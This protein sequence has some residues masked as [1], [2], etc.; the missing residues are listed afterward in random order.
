MFVT[1]IYNIKSIKKFLKKYKSTLLVIIFLVITSFILLITNSK[2][3]TTLANKLADEINVEFG[4][5]IAINKATLSFNGKVDLRDFLIRD[6]K[7]DTLVFFK[8]IYLSPISLGKLVS[9]EL[10]FSSIT[11]DGLDLK[12]S[13][14]LNEDQNSLEIFLKKLN[15]KNQGSLEKLNNSGFVSNVFA[16]NSS[17]KIVNHNTKNS[18]LKIS[19]IDF[20]LIDFEFFDQDF[21]F[22]IDDLKLN[23][24][25]RIE[26]SSL[27]GKVNK[28]DSILFLE[29][30][31]FSFGK[32][33][34]NGNL[35]LDYSNIS[36]TDIYSFDFINS[37]YINLE[38]VDSK[39]SS[40]DLGK[41]LPNLKT[42]YDESWLVNT[43]IKGYLNDLFI[44]NLLLENKNNTINFNSNIKNIFHDNY[45]L[46]FD[47]INFDI[48]S[49]EIDRVFPKFFGT[50]LP[51]SL[52]TFG[53]F[54]MDG[55]V[56]FKTDYVSS[57]FN[58][59]IKQG[60]LKSDLKIFNFSNIDN[61]S[62][63]GTISGFDLDLSSFVNM[64]NI[65]KSSFK[66]EIKGKGFTKEFLN[67]SVNGKIYDLDFNNYKLLNTD[68]TG[69]IK[70]QIFDGSMLVNDDNLSLKF[71]GLIDFSEVLVDFDF[72]LNL[73]NADLNKLNFGIDSQISGLAN[74]KLRGSEIE[75]IIGDLTLSNVIFKSQGQS[76]EF[77]NFNAQ[78]RYNEDVRIVNIRSVDA[79]SG[80][81]IGEYDFFNLKNTF[82]NSFGSDYKNYVSDSGT[83]FQNISFNINFKPKFLSLFNQSIEI[84]E[85]T[86]LSGSFNSNGDYEL[87]LKSNSLKYDGLSIEEVDVK[88][89]SDNGRFEI[90]NIKSIFLEGKELVMESSFLNDT[91]FVKSNYT[92]F[93]NNI[94]KLSF[95]HTINSENNSVF[96]F[97][98][99][100]LILNNMEW[101]LNKVSNNPSLTINRNS[102]E[103]NIKNISFL[104]K[105]QSIDLNISNFKKQSKYDVSFKDVELNSFTNKNSSILFDGKINGNLFLS[106]IDQKFNGESNL[107]I[108]GL[109]SNNEL[110]GDAS[111]NF[112][113]SEN[114]KKINIDFFVINDFEKKLNLFGDF[115]IEENYYPLNLT[116][117]SNNFKISPFSNLIKNSI[118]NFEGEFNSEIKIT[119][120]STNPVFYGNIVTS[121]VAFKVPY[122]NVRYE[123]E[124]KSTFFLNDQ[125][126]YIDDFKLTNRLTNTF[127]NISGKIS[128]NLFK[129]WFLE[130]DINSENLMILNTTLNNNSLY[131]GK[132]MF[133]GNAII[134]GPEKNL[135]I[136]LKGST[137]KNT[138]LVIPIKGSNNVGDFKF[139]NYITPNSE[140]S[141]SKK[142]NKSLL[143]DL[144]IDFNSNANL[145]VILDSESQSRINGF[146]NGRLNFKINTLGNF[147][148]YGNF[149][150]EKG[151]YFYKSLGIVNREFN[152]LKGS[153][154]VWNGD[155]YL[156]DLNINA[157][158]EVPGGANPAILIQNTSFNRKIPTNVNVVL[159]GNFNEMETPDFE[160]EFPNTSGPIKS[161]LDYYLVDKEKKQ[162]QALS[163]LYQ[164]T[165]IDEVS[166]STVSSQAITNNLFQSASGLIDNIFAN[167]DDKMNIGVNYLKGDKNAS[168]S[169]LNRDRLGLTLK[170]EISDKI[171]INGKIGVPVGG[172]EENVVIGDV[173]IEFLL[174]DEGNLKARFFNK[175]NEYQYFGNDIGYTQGMGISYEIDF[176]NIKNLFRKNKDSKS[177]KKSN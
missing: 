20:S 59:I 44:E 91:L 5:E 131:Y 68:I 65:K 133:N 35:K 118:S 165:F 122:L 168:S 166:L 33:N 107:V 29:N 45:S 43:N 48:N 100:D 77:D 58:L 21:N 74:V 130:L 97:T 42:N 78:L 129:N 138:S 76:T 89:D 157:K 177:R 14:Y 53:R 153:R 139:L 90:K 37:T 61:A 66:F 159:A 30:S 64:R 112:K 69:N 110:I 101:S 172:I 152:I 52:K 55:Y 27:K 41:M 80:I 18:R 171:L 17:I 93:S 7:N 162:K 26:L 154:I 22:I 11:F 141:D 150:V 147:N 57:K 127:G 149:E 164:S 34:V 117:T 128:H 85:N 32:S 4:T 148:M 92:S 142:I 121:N 9:K 63:D 83:N 102:N 79:F 13:T 163:L 136:N 50:V 132:G 109:K 60:L 114:L 174:N 24:D 1:K 146:G 135:L 70:D 51:S 169:L 167:S 124:D 96:G 38:I 103:F 170:T 84:D 175:E 82:L 123:I 158:Y 67:S 88:M 47:V 23:F 46:T 104:N 71:N 106:Q 173:Q 115:S 40:F 16:K 94:N 160:I 6:H 126:F 87:G 36:S 3:Q 176:N 73:I 31:K 72:D 156:G 95:Y 62:Y 28:K 116:L 105:D 155:P 120:N 25:N 2:F 143:V 111:L 134:Y 161:E 39:I 125:S 8:N 12:I 15:K 49:E 119:G 86:F 99:L 140:K 151:S 54:K 10:N 75:N 144:D 113:A 56:D 19:N 137:N 145:E 108:S 81:F 98:D